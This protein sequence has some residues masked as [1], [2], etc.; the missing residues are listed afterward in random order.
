MQICDP[1]RYEVHSHP[2]SR[3]SSSDGGGSA[4]TPLQHFSKHYCSN[5]PHFEVVDNVC[6]IELLCKSQ[7]LP[8]RAQDEEITIWARHSGFPRTTLS[9]CEHMWHRQR[10]TTWQQT[11]SVAAAG[12]SA[13]IAPGDLNV[14]APDT[15]SA[16]AEGTWTMGQSLAADGLVGRA[17]RAVGCLGWSCGSA[18][19]GRKDWG[20]GHT[21][22]RTPKDQ[23]DCEHLVDQRSENICLVDVTL[24]G[25]Q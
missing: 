22:T 10:Q 25:D 24:C 15:V 19:G 21:R 14:G 5:S 18:E 9:Q 16:R 13:D 1:C 4:K 3:G 12:C 23:M 20:R 17:R 7:R 8:R 6:L 11:H 2:M